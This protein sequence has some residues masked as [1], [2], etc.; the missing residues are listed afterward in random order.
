M[1]E[2]DEFAVAIRAE[3]DALLGLGTMSVGEEELF[4]RHRQLHRTLHFARGENADDDMRPRAAFAAERAA[5]E[6]RH[7]ADVF[8]RN[9]EHPRESRT[10]G[11]DVLR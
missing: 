10:H 3:A 4:A 1:D 6:R 7:H 9:T 2:G 8:A 11:E 5:D